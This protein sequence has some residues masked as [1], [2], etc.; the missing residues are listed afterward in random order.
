M[1]ASSNYMYFKCSAGKLLVAANGCVLIVGLLF[2]L[3]MCFK[4]PFLPRLFIHAVL[5]SRIL[6]D[7]AC[8][9]IDQP[10]V[11]A[12]PLGLITETIST[13]LPSPM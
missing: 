4:S 6:Y 11:D 7:G 3:H 1:G 2:A 10:K 5:V 9:R 8:L 13:G 12:G